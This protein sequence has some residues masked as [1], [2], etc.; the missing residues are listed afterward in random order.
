MAMAGTK[1]KEIDGITFQV[2]PFMA[3]EALRLKAHL[4]R[5]FGPSLGELLGGLQ[6]GDKLDALDVDISRINIAG[7]LEK[8]FLQLDEDSFV[9]LVQRLFQNTIATWTADG[10]SHSM[11]FNTDF[12]TALDLVFSGRLFT[13]YP[14]ILFVLEVNYPDFFTKVVRGIGSKI[15]LTSLLPTEKPQPPKE[16]PRLEMSDD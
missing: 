4:I 9:R 13:I 3:V 14:A 1:K 11:A 2:A 7:A 6:G 15:N 10:K 8:L 16:Q 5:L 12:S